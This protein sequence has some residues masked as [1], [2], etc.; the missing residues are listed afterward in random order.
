MERRCHRQREQERESPHVDLSVKMMD[1][2]FA[3]DGTLIND[4]PLDR[5]PLSIGRNTSESDQK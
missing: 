3:T 1:V 4:T 2:S 5:H